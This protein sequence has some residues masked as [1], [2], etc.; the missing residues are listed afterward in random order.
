MIKYL[1]CVGYK[2]FTFYD[3][4]DAM[5]FASCCLLHST[6][7]DLSIKIELEREECTNTSETEE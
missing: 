7:P 2:V 1:V 4:M 3:R 5:E 6:D